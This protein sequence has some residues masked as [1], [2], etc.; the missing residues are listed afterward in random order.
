MRGEQERTFV[1]FDVLINSAIKVSHA[2]FGYLF[3]Y[4][5][6]YCL[7][8]YLFLLFNFYY[9]ILWF[10]FGNL[11]FPVFIGES[12]AQCVCAEQLVCV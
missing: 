6:Y 9:S 10:C 5:S 2:L 11:V 8:I 4:V 12:R 7:F 3:I 1:F